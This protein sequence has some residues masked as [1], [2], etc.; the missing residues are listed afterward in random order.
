MGQLSCNRKGKTTNVTVFCFYQNP[1]NEHK[2]IEKFQHYVR[3]DTIVLIW[4]HQ[5]LAQLSST[6][7]RY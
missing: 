6:T 2:C 1:P 5:T 3:E 7:N 4:E